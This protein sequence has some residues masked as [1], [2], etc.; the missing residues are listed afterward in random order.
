MSEPED[1][2]DGQRP[3]RKAP[4]KKPPAT[5]SP[6]KKA[7]AKKAPAKKAAA[8]TTADHKPP[9][10]PAAHPEPLPAPAP[11]DDAAF[12]AEVSGL[13]EPT[14]ADWRRMVRT[15]LTG[16]VTN[17][18]RNP[19]KVLLCMAAGWAVGWLVNVWVMARN[20]GGFVVPSGSPV[21]GQGNIVRGA[22]YW[23]VVSL[24]V[25]A[26][27]N[28]RIMAG[29]ER[30]W[31]DV[32]GFPEGI[33]RLV[34]D[35]GAKA[36]AHLLFG[37]A[38]GLLLTYTLG[39]SLSSVVAVGTALVLVSLLRP[40]VVG[41]LLLAWR[42][43][44]A[45]LAPTADRGSLQ[46]TAVATL[47]GAAALA[48]SIAIHSPTLRILLAVG[49][50]GTAVALSRGRAPSSATVLLV[51]LGAF[52]VDGL[53]EA[54]LA[55]ADDGGWQECGSTLSRW[56]SC[57]GSD[58]ARWLAAYGAGGSALGA[59]L[60]AGLAPTGSPLTKPWSEMSDS[61]REAF[62]QDYINRFLDTHPHA[63]AE[64]LRRFVDGLNS[65]D[66]GFWEKQWQL[67]KDFAGA[68]WDDLAS[69]KQAEGLGAMFY[70]MGEGF[71]KAAKTTLDEL[72]NLPGTLREFPGVFWDDLAS[73]EQEK[74]LKGMVDYT[75]NALKKADQFLNMSPEELAAAYD[76][77]GKANV[78]KFMAKMGEIERNL[79]AKDPTAI[80]QSIGE[81]AG[82]AEFTVLLGAGQEKL[83]AEAAA[84]LGEIKA[85]K[86]AEQTL[87]DIKAG[88][89]G[90]S[91]TE[92]TAD[93]RFARQNLLELAKRD[94]V[95][96]TPEEA[97]RLFGIDERI[98]LQRQ[99]TILQTSEGKAG[100]GMYSEYKLGDENAV[101]AKQL[102][103]EHPDLY[104]G[105][106]NPVADKSFVPGE[107]AFMSAEDLA[108]FKD[109]PPL[110]GETV[111]FTPKALSQQE[112]ADLPPDL[113]SRY[114][115]RMKDA[116]GWDKHTGFTKRE[117]IDY[118]KPGVKDKYGEMYVPEDPRNPVKKAEFWKDPD[119]NRIY[120]RYQTEDGAWSPPR[121][122][123]SDVDTVTHGG[124]EKVSY[125][126][127]RELQ[128]KQSDGQLGEGDTPAWVRGMLEEG[129]GGMELKDPDMRNMLYKG[130]DA[131]DKANGQQVIQQN[132][133]GLFLTTA[134]YSEE[135][136]MATQAAKQLDAQGLW[137]AEQRAALVNKGILAP[138]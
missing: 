98:T 45:R 46:T 124:G 111:N 92:L 126:K 91:V 107:E 43:V 15:T 42:A 103:V 26:L 47:G 39:P 137:T 38:G 119:D 41:G 27:L 19:R 134:N 76:R 84:Y 63:T 25:T 78:Q 75:G 135:L 14:R 128:Y 122:Q 66:A 108:R 64:Q 120:V 70:G 89:K 118:A 61:E 1:K 81:L 34:R 9:E 131:L 31:T 35:D 48:S 23:F 62:K 60:G 86:L 51:L 99:G 11:L 40:V 57:S 114:A 5:T 106:W 68:Y 80:R 100:K 65:R 10:A 72:K 13:L 117:T 87:I 79:A 67:T 109:H 129:K 127:S 24:V 71:N 21:V 97:E 116:A 102:R 77:Y 90:L 136:K 83:T 73:G 115:D 132:L 96:L 101:M 2:G 85:A 18:R 17:L 52:V 105:K 56:W 125:D 104:T 110:P 69:G 112:I 6:A 29:G 12:E 138:R 49:A 113:Q 59:G 53:W 130:I 121:R 133:D 32:R 8:R 22:S 123:A 33:K 54:R 44:I 16:V 58:R 4:A 20:Y 94:K 93:E 7:P 55:L 95:K 3:P 88:T 82:E 37:A 36:T 28:Y 50:A 74:R 30:F